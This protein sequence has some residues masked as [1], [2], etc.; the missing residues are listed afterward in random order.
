[1]SITGINP[2][3]SSQVTATMPLRERLTSLSPKSASDNTAE[4]RKNFTQ[5]VGEAFYG[6]MLKSMRATVGKPAYFH[7]GRAEEV[8]QG[9]LDQEMAQ[10]L[11]ETSADKFAEPM[12][13]RQFPHLA[14]KEARGDLG[15]INALSRR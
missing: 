5:F 7:G 9:Q 1:M 14:K 6:Q 8:F 3:T 13:E 12:F 11:T 15:Q 10:H 2:S 4:L